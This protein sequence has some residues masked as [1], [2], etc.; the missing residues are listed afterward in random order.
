[1]KPGEMCKTR[2]RPE[3]TGL[4]GPL[5]IMDHQ[6]PK[7]SCT[8]WAAGSCACGPVAALWKSSGLCLVLESELQF[9][10][11]LL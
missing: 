1:M 2:L 10:Y 6:P 4:P 5:R 8:G 9:A 7:T 11:L 3:G